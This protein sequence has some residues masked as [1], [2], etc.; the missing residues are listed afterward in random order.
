MQ[1]TWAFCM[2]VHFWVV[3]VLDFGPVNNFL[4]SKKNDRVRAH[5]IGQKMKR[6][7]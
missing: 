3:N 4:L 5:G 6:A 2:V 1:C 7:R